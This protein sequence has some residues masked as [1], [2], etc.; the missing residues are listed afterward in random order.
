MMMNKHWQIQEA[1][2]KLN[3]VVRKAHDEGPQVI[4]VRGKPAAVILSV[5]E[6]QQ[7]KGHQNS[8]T[9]FFDTS[10]LK[11]LQLDLER[12]KDHPREVEL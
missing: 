10:P 2:S 7:L 11:G 8:L 6:F 1:K 4:S 12:N 9:E 3:F 5:E